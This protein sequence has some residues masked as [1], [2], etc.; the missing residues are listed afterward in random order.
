MTG[1]LV[2]FD[3]GCVCE[4]FAGSVVKHI[5]VYSHRIVEP[6]QS[7]VCPPGHGAGGRTACVFTENER[8][9]GGGFVYIGV[10]VRRIDRLAYQL[11]KS[12]GAT[13]AS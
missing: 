11:E 7:Y 13:T 5:P 4:R 3:C 10:A 9:Y 2:K 6:C 12:F 1:E 8:T